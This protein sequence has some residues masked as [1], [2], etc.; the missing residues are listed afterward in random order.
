VVII[1]VTFIVMARWIFRKSF[2]YNARYVDEVMA[3]DERKAITDHKLLV[4]CLV[5]LALII[6]AFSL[7]AVVDVEPSIVALVGAGVMLMVSRVDTSDVLK[8]VEWGVL[9]FFMGLFVMVAGL[10]HTD[11]KSTRLNSSHVKISYA[12]FCLK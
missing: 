2:R 9:V 7:H 1:F 4:R 8:E 5:V 3:L 11:R 12:V 6:V 10:G